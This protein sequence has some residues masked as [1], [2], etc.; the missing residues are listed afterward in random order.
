MP[1]QFPNTEMQ[2]FEK[3]M[4]KETM[5]ASRR[6]DHPHFANVGRTVYAKGVITD[7]E[8]VSDDPIQ[9]ASRVKVK[10]G[11]GEEYDEYIPLFYQPKAQYWDDE[12]A[13]VLATDYDEEFGC[14]KRAWRSF[15]CG[16]EVAVMLQSEASVEGELKPVAVV[17]FA[18][19]VPRIGEAIIKHKVTMYDGGV[20]YYYQKQG[21]RVEYYDKTDEVGPDGVPLRL[22]TEA[23]ADGG[24]EVIY[25]EDDYY[26]EV[27]QEWYHYQWWCGTKRLFV[28][29]GPL[30]F[31]FHYL[32]AKAAP[33]G[34]IP[35]WETNL[36][37]YKV[38]GSVCSEA[39]LLEI[40]E[41]HN[42]KGP[43]EAKQ[44]LYDGGVWW[45][46]YPGF[47]E[48]FFGKGP[49][50]YQFELQFIDHAKRT[51]FCRPHTKEELMAANMWPGEVTA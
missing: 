36:I 41:E 43:I 15:R 27:D 4:N 33:H 20:N 1:V 23:M 16:D 39:E 7:F 14:Y 37:E 44:I 49:F 12:N 13:E 11:E 10:I 3:H 24:V 5:V 32:W 19:G 29:V 6:L 51:I 30:C 26:D 50:E 22:E 35:Y 8:L 34:R 2:V 46:E 48:W 42:P 40:L 9:V 38:T 47:E 21:A 28:F 25:D 45:E 31:C 18:D 17:G